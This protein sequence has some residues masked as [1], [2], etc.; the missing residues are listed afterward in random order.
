MI[1]SYDGQ[2][3]IDMPL[4]TILRIS[5]V[6]ACLAGN[7]FGQLWTDPEDSK[8]PPDFQ[9]QGEYSGKGMGAQVIALGKG[10]LHAVSARLSRS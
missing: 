10:R 5:P 7:T 6:I 4:S 1:D 2:P 3:F 8:L 9:V